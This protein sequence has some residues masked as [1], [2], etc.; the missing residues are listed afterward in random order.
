MSIRNLRTLVA[1]AD[2]GSF[3]AAARDVGP[4]L[5][6]IHERVM[7]KARASLEFLR[8]GLL[9]DLQHLDVIFVRREF[10]QGAGQQRGRGQ[11]GEH[12]GGGRGRSEQRRDQRRPVAPAGRE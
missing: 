5:V 1:V 12:R 7:V 2:H 9:P 4:E 6:V 8:I 11:R 10:H 3:A